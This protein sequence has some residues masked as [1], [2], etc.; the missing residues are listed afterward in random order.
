MSDSAIKWVSS[1]HELE[2]QPDKTPIEIQFIS[3]LTSVTSTCNYYLLQLQDFN[4]N[5]DCY[6]VKVRFNCSTSCRLARITISL[7]Y[8]FFDINMYGKITMDIEDMH[9]RK[10]CFVKCTATYISSKGKSALYLNDIEP[11][12]LN[13]AILAT[14]EKDP[15]GEKLSQLFNDL[16]R[17]EESPENEF[18]FTKL[19]GSTSELFDFIENL[20]FNAIKSKLKDT[21]FSN[22]L[23][24]RVND[25]SQ[26]TFSSQALDSQQPSTI[27]LTSKN[28]MASQDLKSTANDSFESCEEVLP[29]VEEIV[30]MIEEIESDSNTSACSQPR[31]KSKLDTQSSSAIVATA[32]D[33]Q[34]FEPWSLQSLLASTDDSPKTIRCKIAYHTSDCSRLY[35]T[36]VGSK[37]I[38]NLNPMVNCLEIHCDFQFSLK[39]SSIAV[40]EI[41]RKRWIFLHNNNDN[42]NVHSYYWGLSKFENGDYR[43]IDK[44]VAKPRTSKDP[45]ILFKDLQ[46]KLGEVKYA[47]MM[48]LLVS[49]SFEKS[50]FTS[51]VF[52]DFTTNDIEQKYLFDRFIVSFDNK[53]QTN[54]G[55]RVIMYSNQFDQFNRAVKE[56]LGTED[57]RE[58]MKYNE[59][60]LT[61][62][63]IVCKLSLKIQFYNNKLNLIARAIEPV[64]FNTFID[65]DTEERM[66]LTYIYNS[67]ARFIS[68]QDLEPYSYV[69]S[70][71][72]PIRKSSQGY[73]TMESPN[74]SDGVEAV[75]EY[76]NVRKYANIPR[77][78]SNVIN[79][80]IID[81]N[82]IAT[83]NMIRNADD[84]TLFNITAKLIEYDIDDEDFVNLYVTDDLISKKTIDPNRI[85]KIQIFG[86]DNINYFKGNNQLGII[87]RELVDC[88][89]NFKIVRSMVK[90]NEYT[91][92]VSWCPIECTLEELK[93]QLELKTR[94]ASSAT[95]EI[96]IKLEE[97]ANYAIQPKVEVLR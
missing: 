36:E 37:E 17:Y 61:H 42:V 92:I 2:G 26:D 30:P 73:I 72:F 23:M 13:D 83:L 18:K 62:C 55:Y 93:Y 7:I 48:G 76:D 5:N 64:L 8:H 89:L 68:L 14:K 51:M 63:G 80:K 6:K 75:P 60:N 31:K 54:E 43:V 95:Q 65:R 3:V 77:L 32:L 67:L 56:K 4:E 49:C 21:L 50:S 45:L 66:A 84:M 58:M 87:G 20:K 70:K 69:Y 86:R 90:L 40:I 27:F 97:S 78:N 88:Q 91:S 79:Y 85:L 53:L 57:I 15:A 29:M 96:S 9:L 12:R 39:E 52:T 28:A 94:K 59:A 24:Q 41:V 74:M 35:I 22:L 16:I 47:D 38:N 71:C 82:D 44:E 46:L 10:L 1:L 81:E 34:S 19:S 11:I 25:D 33:S